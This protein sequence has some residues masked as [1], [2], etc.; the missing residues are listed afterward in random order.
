M[1]ASAGTDWD[2]GPL[3]LGYVTKCVSGVFVGVW[4]AQFT[5]N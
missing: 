5:L 4:A 1:G 2:R 3:G